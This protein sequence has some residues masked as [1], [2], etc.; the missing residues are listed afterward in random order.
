[1]EA[2]NRELNRNRPSNCQDW[3]DI[4]P[5]S[6]NPQLHSKFYLF[7]FSFALLLRGP[8]VFVNQAINKFNSESSATSK[9][10]MDSSYFDFDYLTRVHIDALMSS[11]ITNTNSSTNVFFSGI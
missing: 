8:Q 1:M 2:R 4:T 5:T 9:S 6:V 7:V 3:F 11:N 10:S